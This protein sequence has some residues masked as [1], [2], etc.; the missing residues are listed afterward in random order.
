M[1]ALI[2]WFS[3][4][5]APP[6]GAAVELAAHHVSAASLETRGGRAS[7]TAHATEPLP[8]GALVP[9]LTAQNVRDRAAV[10]AAVGRVLER[11]GGPRRIGLVVPDPV[12]KVS[13]VRF[14]HVPARAQ[15]LDQLIRWQVRE[16]A[17]FAIEDAAVS[18]VPGLK[19]EEGQEFVVT[20][21]R[22]DI[23]EEYEGVCAVAGAHA[24]LVDISTFNVIN[25]ALAGTGAP[26]ADWLLVNVATDYASI[27]ILRGGDLMFFRS[28]VSDTEGTLADLVH[29]TA[30]YYEDRLK[31][32]G[33]TRVL[34]SGA[35]TA[36]SAHATDV[37]QARRSLQDRLGTSVETVDAS[38]AAN[39]TDRIAAAPA[40]LDTLAPL[41]GLLLRG[42][43]AA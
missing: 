10:A 7:V 34:V 9:G 15:D 8:D 40:F 33:L 2:D 28:R 14:E 37:D 41:V 12:A 1:S 42:K 30:M 19:L 31:G 11:V 26:S 24:G 4:R 20:L 39:L 35:S 3:L 27:A 43:E 21:A 5:N 32:A 36:G 25:A 23:I 29:Q 6:P 17:P 22:R 38:R 18:H 16:A 13:L